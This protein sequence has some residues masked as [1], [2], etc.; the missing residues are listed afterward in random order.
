VAPTRALNVADRACLGGGK[1]L[2]LLTL[3]CAGRG[4]TFDCLTK[5]GLG[6]HHR[7]LSSPGV[8][9]FFRGQWVQ[10]PG[11]PGIEPTAL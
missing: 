2:A 5:R 3:S 10:F 8:L 1:T 6:K 11:V 9:I 7:D 4:P